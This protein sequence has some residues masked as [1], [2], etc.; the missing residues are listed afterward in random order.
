[1]KRTLLALGSLILSCLILC[2]PALAQTPSLN[3]V[4]WIWLENVSDN[5][6]VQQKFTQSLLK[7][8]PS[9][10]F[11][12]FKPTSPVTQADVVSMISGYD[13]GVASNATLKLL[14]PSLVDL[15]MSRNIS[16]RVYSEDYPGSCYLGDSIGNYYRY[17]NP[18]ASIAAVQSDRFRCMN[19]VNFSNYTS[20]IN[21]STMP[22]LMVVIPGLANSGGSTNAATADGMLNTLLTPMINA[23]NLGN[24]TVIVSTTSTTNSGAPVFTMILG[25]GV[26]KVGQSV[27]TSYN[28][29]NLLRTIEEGFGLGNLNQ[30]DASSSSMSG[31]WN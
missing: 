11:T 1:M 30:Q 18:F 16:W 22:K 23:G 27:S 21:F 19:L 26:S 14:A 15:L 2:S 3:R 13:Q 12:N 25:Q 8:Y 4:L 7:K 5:Q 20:D 29:Y 10:H 24:T 28:H 9:V 17:R 31:F 6:M